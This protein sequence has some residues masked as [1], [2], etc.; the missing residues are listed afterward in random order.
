MEAKIPN[1]FCYLLWFKH[2]KNNLQH[3]FYGQKGTNLRTKGYKTTDKREQNHGQKGTT[4][5]VKDAY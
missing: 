5:L 4:T 1:I 2:R 3:K